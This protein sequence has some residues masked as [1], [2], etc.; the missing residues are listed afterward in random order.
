MLGSVWRPG[1][2]LK[3]NRGCNHCGGSGYCGRLALQEVLVLDD[4]LRRAL[5][6]GSS[7]AELRDLS[8]RSGCQSLCA[9]GRRKVLAG[10]T[11]AAEVRRVLYG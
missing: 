4:G 11:T 9:D 6:R 3:R 5:L 7:L 10:L 1:L 8:A 2:T